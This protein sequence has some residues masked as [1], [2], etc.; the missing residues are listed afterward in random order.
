M[1]RLFGTQRLRGKC[2]RKRLWCFVLF[3]CLVPGSEFDGMINTFLL[4]VM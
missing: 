1:K 4:P 2:P 3:V